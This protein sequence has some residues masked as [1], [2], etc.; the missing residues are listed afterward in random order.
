MV[1]GDY[2]I[3]DLATKLGLTVFR[4]NKW[5]DNMLPC[6]TVYGFTSI[7][8]VI[9]NIAEQSRCSW[10]LSDKVI[11]LTNL[12]VGVEET[13]ISLTKHADSRL[14][15]SEAKNTLAQQLAT[16]STNAATTRLAA[17]ESLASS[18]AAKTSSSSSLSAKNSQ[19]GLL[20]AIAAAASSRA[21][22][23]AN[24]AANVS[25]AFATESAAISDWSTGVTSARSN[26]DS[27]LPVV[28]EYVLNADNILSYRIRSTDVLSLYNNTTFTWPTLRPYGNKA[29][30]NLANPEDAL[31]ST[32]NK[33][34]TIFKR[35]EE[36]LRFASF[37][38]NRYSRDWLR[39]EIEG[40]I[41]SLKLES[42]DRVSVTIDG[43]KDVKGEVQSV[44]FN[45]ETG[46]VVLDILL[47]LDTADTNGSPTKLWDIPHDDILTNT[48][49]NLEGYVITD[50]KQLVEYFN[51][52]GF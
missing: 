29:F 8:D 10:F 13:E 39:I 28:A 27:D 9:T 43:L 6:F 34:V 7:L 35:K 1:Y 40:F 11:K 48:S 2:I 24:N 45:H 50:N 17:I 31:M 5:P 19:A 46:T 18:F 33:E 36:A 14:S 47:S 32:S 16:E 37:W 23:I 4:N 21:S 30:I 12:V 22:T 52:K 25:S 42:N 15:A 38:V 3:E 49:S 44:A 26:A 51:A 41:D 20:S